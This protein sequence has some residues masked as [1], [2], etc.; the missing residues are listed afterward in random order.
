M[1]NAGLPDDTAFPDGM[2]TRMVSAEG[3]GKIEGKE[4]MRSRMR[5]A[6]IVTEV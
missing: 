4:K 3:E 1:S 2:A 6:M 5:P